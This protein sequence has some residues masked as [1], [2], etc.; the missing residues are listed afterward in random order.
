ME[1]TYPS[2]PTGLAGATHAILR[3]G[4]GFLFF[5]HGA[6]KLLGWFGGHRGEPGAT[7][8]LFTLIWWSGF[9]E[10]V[11]GFL[12]LVGLFTRPVAVIVALEMVIAYFRSHFP[13]G[14]MPIQNRGELA[15]LYMLVWIFLA[16]NGAGPASLD[17]WI[18]A[19]RAASP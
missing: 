16:G 4:A 9:L 8:E 19:R 17:R 2:Q 14:W 15:L 13:E 12:I 5:Q 11:G 1:A 7:A 3:I 6:P 18:G 10:V